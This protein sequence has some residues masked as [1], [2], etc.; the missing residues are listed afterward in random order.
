TDQHRPAKDRPVPI[1]TY[2]LQLHRDFDFAAVARLAPYLASL[3]VTH[4]YL[5]PILAANPG[6]THGYD[7]VDHAQLAPDLGGR[8]AFDRMVTELGAHGLGVVVDLVPN[9]MAVPTPEWRNAALW[10][11]LRDGPESPY[12]PW[13]DVDWSVDQAALL[14][15]VLGQR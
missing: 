13:F 2:R 15:P 5:S 11:V 9:H 7:V 6:S 10:S 3:G 14:M 4:A 1:S 8:E 12:A